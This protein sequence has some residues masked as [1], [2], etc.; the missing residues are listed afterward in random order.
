MPRLRLPIR[1]VALAAAGLLSVSW[2]PG[3]SAAPVTYHLDPK[4]TF[5][6]FEVDHY[7]GMSKFRGLFRKTSGD[8]V[9]DKAA[10]KGSV[11][12]VIDAASIDFGIEVMNDK[13]RSEEALDAA[14]FPQATY[15]GELVDWVNGAPTKLQGELTLH[16][17]TKPVTLAIDSF[18]CQPHPLLKHDWCGANATGTFRRDEFGITKG[19][20]NG[21]D[22][23]VLL[24]IQVEG[25][26]AE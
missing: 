10:Q 3:A 1:L 11:S 13:V 17:V 14:K 8:V 4:H 24:R 5:P 7:G 18:K 16:G 19:R 26:A 2:V 23:G 25:V 6:S 12:I 22:M 20:E 15:R 9:L 21:F